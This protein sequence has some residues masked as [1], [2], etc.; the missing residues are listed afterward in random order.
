MRDDP[1]VLGFLTVLSAILTLVA[2]H[3]FE[4][5]VAYLNAER[6]GQPLPRIDQPG[7]SAGGQLVPDLAMINTFPRTSHIVE[8]IFCAQS[9]SKGT[10]LRHLARV[11]NNAALARARA[12]EGIA[13]G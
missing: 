1:F 6:D 13:A 10:V 9:L 8:Y 5:E 12:S 11:L 7:G 3:R 4:Q 2:F